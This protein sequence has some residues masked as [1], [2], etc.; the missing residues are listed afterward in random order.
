MASLTSN[1]QGI[2]PLGFKA[3][4]TIVKNRLVKLDSTAGQ[5]I[6]CTAITDVPVGVA[7]EAA[8]SGDTVAVQTQGVAMVVASGVV[9]LG[10][11]VMPTASGAG[12][13]I[14]AAGATAQSVGVALAAA[15]AD[16]DEI[17]VLLRIGVNGPANS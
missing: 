15:A 16:L 7:L 3:G 17:P 9:A 6:A 14:T 10:A 12:K 2:S 1:M 4:G 5:V 13:C 11:Q 8:S